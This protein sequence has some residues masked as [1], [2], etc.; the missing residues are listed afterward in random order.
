MLVN[1]SYIQMRG[2]VKE[3]Y[4]KSLSGWKNKDVEFT[5]LKHVLGNS[6][7]QFSPYMFERGIKKSKFSTLD[8]TNCLVVDIDDGMSINEWQMMYGRFKWI[9]GTTKSNMLDKKGLVCE[10]F[11]IIIP[12]INIPT[13]RAVFFRM[14]ELLFPE[15]D[16]QTET[17]TGA[18]LGHT[19]A[20]IIVNDGKLLDCHSASDMAKEQID[21]EEVEK[22]LKVVDRDLLP[23]YGRLDPRAIRESLTVENTIDIVESIGYEVIGC[24]FKLREE[25]RSASAK[26]YS[27]GFIV[28]YGGEFKADIFQL[29]MDYNGMSFREALR[30]VNN[31]L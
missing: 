8:K 18:F 6:N 23:N 4:T 28:D 27:N 15:N 21:S 29:L 1:L 20:T 26:I 24:K 30:Y 10:R 13:E 25:E 2:S 7:I 14:L 17:P 3:S 11:R 31:I 12:A 9:L 16:R 19:G 22:R 5:S